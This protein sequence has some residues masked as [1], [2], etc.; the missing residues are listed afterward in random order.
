M[1]KKFIV[2]VLALALG[3]SSLAGCKQG[4]GNK[5][6]PQPSGP[7]YTGIRLDTTAMDL[8][9]EY[10]ATAVSLEGLVVYAQYSDSTEQ[11]VS[12]GYTWSSLEISPAEKLALRKEVTITYQSKSAKINYTILP[13]PIP[14]W[15]ET[16]KALMQ[17]H[18]AGLTIPYIELGEGYEVEWDD[19]DESIYIE[20][21]NIDQTGLLNYAKTW[22]NFGWS[23]GG[24]EYSEGVQIYNFSKEVA[25]QDDAPVIVKGAFCAADSSYDP[26]ASGKF[27]LYAQVDESYVKDWPAAKALDFAKKYSGSDTPTA[28]IAGPGAYFKVI[29]DTYDQIYGYVSEDPHYDQ[30]YA[31]TEWTVNAPGAEDEGWYS[32]VSPEEN[33][34]LYYQY[35]ASSGLYVIQF[36]SFY[37]PVQEWPSDVVNGYIADYKGEDSV[38]AFT[39]AKIT[40]FTPVAASKRLNINVNAGDGA[41]VAAALGDFLTSSEN[42]YTKV[43]GA[44]AVQNF[45]YSEHLNIK[46]EVVDMDTY[47]SGSTNYVYLVFSGVQPSYFFGSWYAKHEIPA[48]DQ[49]AGLPTFTSASEGV[50]SIYSSDDMPYVR[51]N[52]ADAAALEAIRAAFVAAIEGAGFFYEGLDKYSCPNYFSPNQK[53]QVGVEVGSAYVE[54]YASL[55][56]E[57]NKFSVSESFPANEIASYLGKEAPAIPAVAGASSFL[58]R[59][60]QSSLNVL[61]KFANAEAAASAVTTYAGSLAGYTN[62]SEGVYVSADGS[63][64][65]TLGTNGSYMSIAVVDSGVFPLSAMGEWLGET[66]TEEQVPVIEKTEGVK[67]SGAAS[68]SG[69]SKTYTVTVTYGT[70]EAA[71]TAASDYETALAGKSFEP[72][73]ETAHL[74]ANDSLALQAYVSVSDKVLT[75]TFASIWKNAT[76]YRYVNYALSTAF[77]SSQFPAYGVKSYTDIGFYVYEGTYYFSI[78][79]GSA[80]SSVLGGVASAFN[81]NPY[82]NYLGVQSSTYYFGSI[83]YPWLQV[84]IYAGYNSSYQICVYIDLVVDADARALSE[85]LDVRYY[86]MSVPVI[87]G[88]QGFSF[89]VNSETGKGYATFGSYETEA[90]ALTAKSAYETALH[91]Y[92]FTQFVGYFFDGYVYVTPSVKSQGEGTEQVWY[93]ELEFEIATPKESA[94]YYLDGFFAA[95]QSRHYEDFV[96]A[97]PLARED[98]TVTDLDV[99]SDFISVELTFA[100]DTEGDDPQTGEVKAGFAAISYIAQLTDSESYNFSFVDVPDSDEDYYLSADGSIKVYVSVEGATLT[101]SIQKTELYAAAAALNE[102][103][104]GGTKVYSDYFPGINQVALLDAYVEFAVDSEEPSVT[105]S[106]DF[107]SVDDMVNVTNA[108]IATFTAKGFVE[109][110]A[111]VYMKDNGDGTYLVIVFNQNEE[112]SS[113]TIMYTISEE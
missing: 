43:A 69:Y 63:I 2:P 4:G 15:S 7:T 81:S 46:I 3:T 16:E 17:E 50:A 36:E 79:A 113:M 82:W 106:F 57:S 93:V 75:I 25:R 98:V 86:T 62:P 23:C 97:L 38:P 55:V 103:V 99:D 47:T 71:A 5:P 91:G 30:L 94:K 101:I 27:F 10:A 42:K 21:G 1:K 80:Y 45:Y 72:D 112:D 105:L 35:F 96:P 18:L 12:S 111:G 53:V 6:Q 13:A 11:A 41:E 85:Y 66:Y 31:D 44:A 33:Y 40:S 37:K 64:T 67:I 95:D 83:V 48:A 102:L 61:A 58:Y 70:A 65:L 49:V 54:I 22:K 56:E 77:T 110:Y 29:E 100:D 24:R 52:G 87:N 68:G 28:P 32:I 39:H 76:D 73:E 60:E 78:T 84:A 26:I 109:G 59:I 104:G 9:V 107:D 34:Q 89:E 14:D 51:I 8:E 90:D 108:Y 20:G 19:S 74:F 88:G 92:G